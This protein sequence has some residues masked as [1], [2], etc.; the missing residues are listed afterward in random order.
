[1]RHKLPLSLKT[2]LWY[3]ITVKACVKISGSILRCI[4]TTG[5]K[6]LIFY[7]S[8][9]AQLQWATGLRARSKKRLGKLQV[10]SSVLRNLEL[11]NEIPMVHGHMR[12]GI[13]KINDVLTHF[14]S[15][16][17]S[18]HQ[19]L[20]QY[21]HQSHCLLPHTIWLTKWSR[22]LAGLKRDGVSRENST[23]QKRL[24]VVNTCTFQCR[25]FQFGESKFGSHQVIWGEIKPRGCS[26]LLRVAR[27]CSGLYPKYSRLWRDQ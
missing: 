23:I 9:L 20:S 10:I 11:C 18:V 5:K 22:L 7:T 15:C 1:M 24:L 3:V 12:D 4:R 16:T 8:I 6:S 25:W 27:G 26:G 13:R 17:S 19:C 2:N 21:F 14:L